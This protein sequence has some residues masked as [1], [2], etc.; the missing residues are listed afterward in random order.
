MNTDFLR[1]D[2]FDPFF[3]SAVFFGKPKEKTNDFGSAMVSDFRSNVRALLQGAVSV[4]SEFV[5]MNVTVAAR[6]IIMSVF[7]E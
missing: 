5:E 3:M 1:F 6:R 4:G 7:G 2:L